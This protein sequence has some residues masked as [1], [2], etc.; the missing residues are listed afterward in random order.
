MSGAALASPAAPRMGRLTL[1]LVLL[2]AAGGL[3]ALVVRLARRRARPT[4]A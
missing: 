1:R 3:V 4:S 2:G